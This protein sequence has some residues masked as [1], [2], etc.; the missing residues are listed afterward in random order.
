LWTLVALVGCAGRQTPKENVSP[1]ACSVAPA[2]EHPAATVQLDPR[3][4]QSFA[5]ATV[6]EPPADWQRPP[7]VTIT[8]KSIGKLYTDVVALWDQIKFTAPTGNS[9]GYSAVLDTDLGPIRI[10][11]L[12]HIAPNHV[13]SFVAL[14]KSGY[15][16]G[17]VFDRTIHEE[18]GGKPD[19]RRELIEAGCPLGRGDPGYGSIGYWLKPEFNADV[20][21]EEGTVG[22]SHG[23]EE[24]TAACKFYITLCKSPYMDGNYT[25]FG[26][27]VSGLDIAKKILS[28][29][30]R[31]DPEFPDGDRPLRPVVIRKVTIETE[32]TDSGG[33]PN[34]SKK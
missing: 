9:I 2:P 22:A 27:V 16:D 1:Q 14:A 32:E 3:L 24:D 25:V 12:P 8:G 33:P 19:A 28:L 31:N 34:D 7:D 15:Y 4:H 26:T 23:E 21:H 13:R 11:L 17:L 20:A 10:K 5:E 6:E 30:V 18:I 29:P